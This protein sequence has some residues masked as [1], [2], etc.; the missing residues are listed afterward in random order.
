[1][2]KPLIRGPTPACVCPVCCGLVG[3][4]S[5][6][7][8]SGQLVNGSDVIPKGDGGAPQWAAA[9]GATGRQYGGSLGLALTVA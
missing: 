9:I 5:A 7:R 8:P 1:M 2:P 4:M 3:G 6:V